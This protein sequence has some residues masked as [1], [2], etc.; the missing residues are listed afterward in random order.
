MCTETPALV[1]A[2][3][4]LII[5]KHLLHC[6]QRKIDNFDCLMI[7]FTKHLKQQ[8]FWP[9][10]STKKLTRG[11][12]YANTAYA[13]ATSAMQWQIAIDFVCVCVCVRVRQCSSGRI[14]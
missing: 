5:L 4:S 7:F 8:S 14:M 12:F 6:Q 2:F 10:Y 13:T 1:I 3:R 9:I 11:Y